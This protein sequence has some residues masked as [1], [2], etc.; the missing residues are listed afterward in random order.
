MLNANCF[1]LVP[2]E[3][4]SQAAA[5]PKHSLVFKRL[6]VIFAVLAITLG[7]AT[8]TTLAQDP[9]AADEPAAKQKA[10]QDPATAT[11]KTKKEAKKPPGLDEKIDKGF[12]FLTGWFV[13]G[14]FAGVPIIKPKKEYVE[15]YFTDHDK[16]K[17]GVL[18]GD[19]IE[20]VDQGQFDTTLDLEELIAARI[21]TSA[22]LPACHQEKM[23]RSISPSLIRTRAAI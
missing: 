6:L 12:G 7:Q 1:A 23:L 17:N 9:P 10:D 4:N 19:E 8:G 5:K 16:D 13:K 15:K 11:A 18:E 14:I 3:P 21:F 2:S 22:Y 20:S